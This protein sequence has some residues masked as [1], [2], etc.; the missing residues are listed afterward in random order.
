VILPRCTRRP[1]SF[2]VRPDPGSTRSRC[3]AALRRAAAA[4][5]RHKRLPDNPCAVREPGLPG[6][7]RVRKL[8]P[9]RRRAA[10][11]RAWQHCGASRKRRRAG[12]TLQLWGTSVPQQRKAG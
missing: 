3:E 12:L 4:W 5:S 9:R 2:N 6:P 10:G 7:R 1:A 11:T 8:L